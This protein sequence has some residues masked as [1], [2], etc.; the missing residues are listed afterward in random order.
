MVIEGDSKQQLFHLLTF[1]ITVTESTTYNEAFTHLHHQYTPF[2]HPEYHSM[3]VMPQK[4]RST[5]FLTSQFL[6]HPQSAG[7]GSSCWLCSS[8]TPG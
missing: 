1:S 7:F 5:V 4:G 3:S 6:F 2:L 8:S